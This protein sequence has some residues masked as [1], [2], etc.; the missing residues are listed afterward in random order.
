MIKEVSLILNQCFGRFTMSPV[1]GPLNW[2]LLDIYL[3][4]SFVVGKLRNIDNLWGSAFFGNVRNLMQI[5]KMQ[6]KNWEKVFCFLDKWI[7][8]VRIQLSLLIRE[9]LS[10]VVIMLRKQLKNFHVSKS[11]F[12]NS[13]AFTVITQDDKG[14]L[15]N[16]ESVVRTVYHVACGGLLSNGIF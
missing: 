9:Y 5:R 3:S 14:P 15:I 12:C 13:I 6:K 11:N 10:S 2:K 16:I 1:Y 8:I 7:W 4:T